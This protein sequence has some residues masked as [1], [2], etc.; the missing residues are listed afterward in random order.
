MKQR[1]P[2]RVIAVAVVFAMVYSMGA[3][4]GIPA[5]SEPRVVVPPAGPYDALASQPPQSGQ[6]G[7]AS[8]TLYFIRNTLIVAVNRNV[9]TPPTADGAVRELLEGP[10]EEERSRGY[11]SALPGTVVINDIRLDN[12]LA[13]VNVGAGLEGARNDESRA[14]GQIVCT[15]DARTDVQRVSFARD[16][17]PISVPA[18]DGKITDRPLT[19]ADYTVLFG[20]S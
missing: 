9:A 17:K 6:S 2:F 11:S 4:C 12:G 8:M 20:P 15:L 10:T 19:T 13:V 3:A 16:G 5:D 7:E 1:V 18:G 14:F